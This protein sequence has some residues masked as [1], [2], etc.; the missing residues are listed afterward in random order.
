MSSCCI[1][2]ISGQGRAVHRCGSIAAPAA[3]IPSSGVLSFPPVQ[4]P[5]AFPAVM[6]G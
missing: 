6:K 5:A 2:Q 4:A 1:G 3:P